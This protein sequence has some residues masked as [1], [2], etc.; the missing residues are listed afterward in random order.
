MDGSSVNFAMPLS[1][2]ASSSGGAIPLIISSQDSASIVNS[3]GVS[4]GS[5]QQVVGT[6][7]P[8]YWWG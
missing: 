2:A 7:P 6:P 5:V 4:R 3:V 1:D 8:I